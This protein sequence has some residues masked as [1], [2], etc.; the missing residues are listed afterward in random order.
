M[1][2]QPPK[3]IKKTILIPLAIALATFLAVTLFLIIWMHRSLLEK[4]NQAN[5]KSVK[6]LFAKKLETETFFISSQ[7]DTLE[8]NQDL[9]TAFLAND[10]DRLQKIAAPI[11]DRMLNKYHLSHFY[12]I[13]PD[14]T[15]FL[16]AHRPDFYGDTITRLT[17]ESAISKNITASGLELGP[18][19]TLTLRVVRPWRINGRLAG[20]LEIGRDI[21][22]ILPELH[23]ILGVHL[24][25]SINRSRLPIAK[26]LATTGNE[27]HDHLI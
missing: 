23:D 4:T 11:F 26:P 25:A 10:R 15:C 20:Y 6:T 27:T 2:K 24:I 17:L 12:F 22:Q 5:L 3:Q 16:R 18:L 9:Q 7:L 21:K 19:G 13:N 1:P 14:R 8:T